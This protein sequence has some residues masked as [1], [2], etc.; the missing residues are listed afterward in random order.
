MPARGARG[1]RRPAGGRSGWS[2]A[3]RMN[4]SHEQ[5]RGLLFMWP[6]ATTT[7]TRMTVEEYLAISEEDARRMEL[8]DGE[9]VVTPEPRPAHAHLQA[10][11]IYA[12]ESWRRRGSGRAI[13]FGPTTVFLGAHDAYGPDLIVCRPEPRIDDRGWL[14]EHPLV[15]VEIRSPTTWK[16]DVGRKKAVYESEGVPELWLVDDVARVV[17]VFRRSA[18]GIDY[19]DTA[20]ELDATDTLTSPLLPGFEL[21]LSELF[22]P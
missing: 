6:M 16:N 12:V 13:V 14:G 15:C 8:I 19:F 7:R 2:R 22:E 9:I 1:S 4:S 18:L 20:L 5:R 21:A 11:L 3:P 10:E 17:L